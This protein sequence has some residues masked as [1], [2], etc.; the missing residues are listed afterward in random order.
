MEPIAPMVTEKPKIMKQSA[1]DR[2]GE[3]L[4]PLAFAG[5]QR[6]D[7]NHGEVFTSFRN[8]SPIGVGFANCGSG[9]VATPNSLE[10]FKQH[11]RAPF[12]GLLA[13]SRRS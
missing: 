3:E 5:T 7:G 9:Q 11:V 10:Q 8:N 6:L 12:P 1:I 13:A 4:L 2:P